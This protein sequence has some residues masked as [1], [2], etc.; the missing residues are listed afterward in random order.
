MN[1][2]DQ[3]RAEAEQLKNRIRDAQ[4]A[5]CDTNLVQAAGNLDPIGRIQIRI[6]KTL[7]GHLAKIYAMHWAQDSRY[8][9][10]TQEPQNK[11]LLRKFINKKISTY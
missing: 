9:V 6:R 10:K 2:L 4:K 8:G 11:L 5:A 1:E 7:R 3:L